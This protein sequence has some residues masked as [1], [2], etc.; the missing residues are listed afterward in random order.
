MR[1]G[2]PPFFVSSEVLFLFLF[3]AVYTEIDEKSW[4]GRR[5][6]TTG[7]PQFLVALEVVFLHRSKMQT[8]GRPQFLVS[9]EGVFLLLLFLC[10]CFLQ[11]LHRNKLEK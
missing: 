11:S 8:T 5:M 1:T 3:F 7:R 10:C 6:P 9:L 2:R 4:D